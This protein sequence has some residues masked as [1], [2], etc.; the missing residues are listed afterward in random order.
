VQIALVFSQHCFSVVDSASHS[1]IA[2]NPQRRAFA[3][4]VLFTILY[5]VFKAGKPT[6]MSTIPSSTID[7]I[8]NWI[9]QYRHAPTALPPEMQAL[10]VDLGRQ[11]EALG[12]SGPQDGLGIAN[13]V[14]M[15]QGK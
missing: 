11:I 10:L 14:G 5:K 7:A 4:I 2:D 3:A 6:P 9:T 1:Y 13:W 8:Q 12:A 15:L